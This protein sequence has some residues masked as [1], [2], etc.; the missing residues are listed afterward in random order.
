[1]EPTISDWTKMPPVLWLFSATSFPVPMEEVLRAAA[2]CLQAV[3][4]PAAHRNKTLRNG[5]A[6]CASALPA[7]NSSIRR[8]NKITT[9]AAQK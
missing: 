6:V 1:M 8:L 7:T 4:W 3:A 9:K 2:K 5:E